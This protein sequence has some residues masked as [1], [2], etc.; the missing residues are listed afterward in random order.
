[1]NKILLFVLFPISIY[2]NKDIDF[3]IFN[4]PWIVSYFLFSVFF[5]TFFIFILKKSSSV[6]SIIIFL[7]NNYKFNILALSTN[8][9]KHKITLF[10][11]F[12]ATSLNY[13]IDKKLSKKQINFRFYLISKY[14]N[15]LFF[16]EH[17]RKKDLEN[18]YF[19]KLNLIIK[20]SNEVYL[21]KVPINLLIKNLYL[22]FMTVTSKININNIL[23]FLL[24][25][26]T[27]LLS[28]IYLIWSSYY[29]KIVQL[30]GI[31]PNSMDLEMYPFL[32]YLFTDIFFLAILPILVSF[33]FISVF[34]NLILMVVYFVGRFI[35]KKKE[36]IF[37]DTLYSYSI[38][39]FFINSFT[40]FFPILLIVWFLFNI[41]I[42]YYKISYPNNPSINLANTKLYMYDYLKYSQKLKIV[43]LNTV[44]TLIVG[45]DENFFQY[46]DI[47][48]NKNDFFSKETKS[49][50][51]CNYIINNINYSKEEAI[52]NN[53]LLSLKFKSV[54]LNN[55]IINTNSIKNYKISSLLKYEERT[56]DFKKDFYINEI[57]SKCGILVVLNLKNKK[58]L[59]KKVELLNNNMPILTLPNSLFIKK[60]N[61]ELD[62]ENNK[63][64]E[65][66]KKYILEFE[67]AE[68]KKC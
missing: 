25:F 47:N 3:S 12:I 68:K 57:V 8:S 58:E 59:L 16:C 14:E 10:K 67:L 33:L 30:L 17:I 21:L 36:D 6:R 66:N 48:K 52:K 44:D 39:S 32:T 62:K 23:L 38:K 65:K 40:Y 5:T 15:N 19:C 9:S 22:L 60:L 20:R 11:R 29:I 64:K 46:I 61:S 43:K 35:L 54:L 13:S 56:V 41:L 49:L 34:F 50:K 55:N 37:Y 26:L 7:E 24:S 45:S 4:Y 42:S 53:E 31:I 2:A 18:D 1:M 28:T 27:I 63:F 51:N